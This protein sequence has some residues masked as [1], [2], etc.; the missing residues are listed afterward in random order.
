MFARGQAAALAQAVDMLL[1]MPE[2]A[3]GRMGVAGRAYYEEHLS[4]AVG[5]QAFEE[6]FMRAACVESGVS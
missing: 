3:R 2:S 5:V 6:E 4:L 1:A